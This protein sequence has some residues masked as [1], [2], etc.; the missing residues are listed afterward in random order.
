MIK[1][2]SRIECP[3]PTLN[4]APNPLPSLNLNRNLNPIHSLLTQLRLCGVGLALVLCPSPWT[5][6]DLPLT[7]T[8]RCRNLPL[9]LVRAEP[10]GF[11]FFVGGVGE[12]VSA[13]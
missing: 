4:L 11:Q 12:W 13:A 7:P 3:N 1:S 5:Q 9:S 10:P 8:S 2:K 6:G